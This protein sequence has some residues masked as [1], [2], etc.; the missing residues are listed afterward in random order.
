[1]ESTAGI[2]F[3]KRRAIEVL[4]ASECAGQESQAVKKA[5]YF[6]LIHP[7]SLRSLK[8]EATLFDEEVCVIYREVCVIYSIGYAGLL[9]KGIMRNSLKNL[10]ILNRTDTAGF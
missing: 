4:Y 8:D 9:V 7:A 10:G 6:K 1:V 3:I 5:L 2:H